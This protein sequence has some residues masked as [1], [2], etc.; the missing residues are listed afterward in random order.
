ML[1]RQEVPD[2]LGD[3]RRAALAAADLDRKADFAAGV[4]LQV[5]AD[6]M[7]LDRRRGRARRRSPRS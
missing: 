1:L 4:R 2:L 5:Q 6:V 3:H 7:H